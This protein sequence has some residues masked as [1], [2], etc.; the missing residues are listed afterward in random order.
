MSNIKVTDEVQKLLVVNLLK[1]I[2]VRR[3]F[4]S[5][6]FKG[7]WAHFLFFDSD[8]MFDS[9]FV[10]NALAMLESE[11]CAAACITELDTLA[12]GMSFFLTGNTH[13]K[14]YASFLVERKWLYEFGRFGCVSTSNSWCMYCERQ[15]EIAV[16]AL[17]EEAM[18]L[19]PVL[20]EAFKASSIHDAVS[21]VI[22][23]G[24][25]ERALSKEWRAELLKQYAIGG[26]GPEH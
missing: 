4:P 9:K 15:S 22:S 19:H 17:K 12:N 1:D 21:E 25:S 3:R 26:G 7:V 20:S 18:S 6:V 11:G 10:N 13:P 24:F 14:D 8:W 16:V 23:Y 2:D 5:Q